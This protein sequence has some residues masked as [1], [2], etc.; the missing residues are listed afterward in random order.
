M[1]IAPILPDDD[2][3]EKVG[4]SLLAMEMLS[5]VEQFTGQT[6]PSSILFEARTIH[7]LAA[8][9]FELDIQ[10]KPLIRLNASSS[11]A[12]LFL[13]HG[14]YAGGG[15]YAARL[16]K[17]L[18]SDQPLFVIAPHDLGR[19]AYSALDRNNSN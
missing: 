6:I 15:L 13:F 19:V 5:E 12:P 1:K 10:S 11:L 9:L 4:D 2:F 18:G 16:A 7:E 17:L 3:L 14:D 8:K